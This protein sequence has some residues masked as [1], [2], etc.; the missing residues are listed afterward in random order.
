MSKPIFK[1][2][3]SPLAVFALNVLLIIFFNIAITWPDYDIPM[4]ILGGA[5][6]GIAAILILKF[7]APKNKIPLPRGISTLFILGLVTIAAVWYEFAEYLVDYFELIP[8]VQMQFG[9]RDTMGDLFLG[10]V[11]GLAT[12]L[13]CWFKK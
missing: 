9:L 2:L 7:Y 11:G 5:S 12:A 13:W 4:H 1:I 8:T 3:S 10:T 6:I